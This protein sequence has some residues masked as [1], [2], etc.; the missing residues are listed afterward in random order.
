[1]AT[2][3]EIKAFIKEIA[4]FAQKA[5]KDMGKINPS[6][7]IG[8]ACVESAYG[9]SQIMRNHNAF[10]GQKV[11]TGRTATKYWSKKAFSTM[12]KEEYTLGA[13]TSITAAFRA[14]DSIEQCVFNFYELLNTSL[15]R[16][17]ENTLDYKQQMKQIK[18]CG[19]MTS[20]TEVNSVIKIIEKYNLV[21][22]DSSNS[23]VSSEFYKKYDGKSNSIVIALD[24]L[25]IDSTF[26]NRKKIADANGIKNYKGTVQ[27][28][29]SILELLKAGKLK[30]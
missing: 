23:A 26:E 27:Q 20:S 10:F 14:Y 7:C 15:Y 13:H 16:Y 21:V 1:M 9:K 30:K 4:P 18:A 24:S 3:S 12:T 2:E 19:Y 6:V 5:Y 17:V 11:G 25:L 28:N 22:Y 29:L 8:I